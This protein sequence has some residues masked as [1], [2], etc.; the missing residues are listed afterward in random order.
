MGRYQSDGRYTFE[1]ADEQSPTTLAEAQERAA[2]ENA[3]DL[4]RVYIF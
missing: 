2:K 1:D 3:R 4:S